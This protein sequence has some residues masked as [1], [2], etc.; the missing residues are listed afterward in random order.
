MSN[1][2]YAY[3]WSGHILTRKSLELREDSLIK[4][5]VVPVDDEIF[6]RIDDDRSKMELPAGVCAELLGLRRY[7]NFLAVGSSF[8][9]GWEF[10]GAPFEEAELRLEG[11]LAVD[12]DAEY[13]AVM[14]SRYGLELPPCRLMIGCASEH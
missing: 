9:E 13:L 3:G 4:N 2:K 1:Y 12:S 14:K 6:D 5:N 8:T 11:A 7:P 10:F